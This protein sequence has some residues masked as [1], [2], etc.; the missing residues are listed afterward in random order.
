MIMT[1]VNWILAAGG[2]AVLAA[3]V[4]VI[5]AFPRAKKWRA[6]CAE[7]MDT[8]F[9][10]WTPPAGENTRDEP[11]PSFEGVDWA[12]LS[13]HVDDEGV[14]F[15]DYDALNQRGV[16]GKRRIPANVAHFAI[17]HAKMYAETGNRDD[18]LI[19][20]RQFEYIAGAA[21]E[22]TID[23]QQGVLWC[24]DF[25]L[26]YQYNVT[27]PWSSAYFQIYCMNALLWAHWLFGDARYLDIAEKGLV[28]L[29]RSIEEG[30]LG[31]RTTGGGLFF[32]EVVSSPPHH[33]LNGHFHALINV[34][35]FAEYTGLEQAADLFD[36]G[37]TALVDMLP[38]FE[39]RGYSL[40]SLAPNPGIRN[41]F[42]IANPFYHRAHI[43]M[44]RKLHELTDNS[45]F[46]DYAQCWLRACDGV[47]D[48][49][50]SVLL[51]M[52]RDFRKNIK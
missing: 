26:G 39:W 8:P 38:R 3:A 31:S 12:A 21:T 17:K 4:W 10:A 18:L 50:W 46:V 11:F 32:E 14:H 9:P 1:I 23:S 22:V 16:T 25:D 49:L 37:V 24:A 52:F 33:I 7:D 5:S 43:R 48:T 42:N 6:R 36:M 28:P 44:L 13:P 27:A 41:H 40:Y 30:G 2:L 15:F 20:S 19:C 51:I 45:M 29:V 35:Y 47:F 34:H